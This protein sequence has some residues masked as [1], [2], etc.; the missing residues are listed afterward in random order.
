MSQS[1]RG[2]KM[3]R[4]PDILDNPNVQKFKSALKDLPQITPS[5]KTF[6]TNS[7]VIGSKKDL[8]DTQKAQIFDSLK[9]L[10]PWRKG[11][12]NLFG[13]EIDAEWDSSLKWAR[14]E[15]HLNLEHKKVLDI[16]CNNGY[17]M[18]KMLAQNPKL[19]IGI[20]PYPRVYYQFLLLQHF[21]QIPNLK[22]HPIGFEELAPFPK[23]F[24]TVFCMGII[25]HHRS[26][27]EVLKNTTQTLKKGGE[28]ILE[29]LCLD[30]PED[31]A[32]CPQDRYAGMRNVYFIPSF[33][34]LKNWL[35][36]TGFTNIKKISLDLTT[37]EEQRKTAWADY[38]P[39]Q[40]GLRRTD[41]KSCVFQTIEGYPAPQRICVKATCRL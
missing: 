26:P 38:D 27:F 4:K 1:D 34:C 22:F 28:L 14:L 25:Y 2:V 6:T 12:F 9:T 7:V 15:K 23:Y 19:V 33:S 31:I 36:R 3:D 35:T 40:N 32:L 17:Y 24:D 13:I 30:T 21:A 5:Q 39:L 29:T 10:K 16:G 20:D 8:N 41:A 37:S 11:P 18:F